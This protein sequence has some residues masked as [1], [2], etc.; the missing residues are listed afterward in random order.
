MRSPQPPSGF[1]ETL[2]YSDRGGLQCP[3]PLLPISPR[4]HNAVGTKGS[5]GGGS[6][7]STGRPYANAHFVLDAWE[8]VVDIKFQPL[9]T[10]AEL[11]AWAF[12]V[13]VNPVP[14]TESAVS[15]EQMAKCTS[16]PRPVSLRTMSISWLLPHGHIDTSQTLP[17]VV[18][19]LGYPHDDPRYLSWNARGILM[20]TIASGEG[21]LKSVHLPPP[22]WSRC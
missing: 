20:R 10:V 19:V 13:S 3:E 5:L 6:T 11:S 14:E 12:R 21:E 7:W 2:V 9:A 4:A 16:R 18:H 1:L 22:R 8:R 15:M 17:P